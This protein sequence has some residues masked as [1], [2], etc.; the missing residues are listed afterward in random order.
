MKY[1]IKVGDS[2]AGGSADSS[3]DSG[4]ESGTSFTCLEDE[5]LLEAMIRARS[6]PVHYGCFGG[7]CGICKMRIVSGSYVVDKHMSRAHVSEQEE[8]DGI[9]LICCVKPRSDLTLA[10]IRV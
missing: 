6:G 7:G 5:F 8:E 1:E 10:Q 4:A 9:A 2:G 3:A